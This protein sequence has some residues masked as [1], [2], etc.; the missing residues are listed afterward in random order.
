M[1]TSVIIIN[2]SAHSYNTVAGSFPYNIAKTALRSLVQSLTIEW[3]PSIRTVGLAPGFIETTLAKQFFN[4]SPDP[5]AK[6]TEI[7][8]AYPLKRL[9][10]PEEIGRW[11]V[12]F[13]SH[14]SSFVGG[15][16]FLMVGGRS[17][18]MM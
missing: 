8:N 18:I 5:Q 2:S 4:E 15:Q 11:F 13:A 12:F 16:T 14:Y 9:G 6:R 7:E 10:T 1:K 17:A 3:G